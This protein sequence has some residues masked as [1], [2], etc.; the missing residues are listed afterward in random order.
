SAGDVDGDGFGDI[1]VGAP[2]VG[3]GAG[4]VHVFYGSSSGIGRTSR[5]VALAGSPGERF[6]WA[7]AAPDLAG[8]GFSDVV[9]GA[10]GASV[11]AGAVRVYSGGPGGLAA[12]DPTRVQAIHGAAGQFFGTILSD[13]GDID[14]D[15]FA[16]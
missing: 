3:A 6:G 13:G 4:A 1:A 15:G 12:S 14:G 10:P 7:V 11:N 8:N 16:D 5:R 9:V 2:R